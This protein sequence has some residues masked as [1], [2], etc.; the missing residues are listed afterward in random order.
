MGDG[1]DE[2]GGWGRRGRRVGRIKKGVGHMREGGRLD[3]G[4]GWSG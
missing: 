3:E 1:A 2:E 4:R